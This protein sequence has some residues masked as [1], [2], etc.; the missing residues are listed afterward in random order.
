MKT[1]AFFYMALMAT[2]MTFAAC[3]QDDE[4][5]TVAPKVAAIEFNINDGGYSGAQTR[6]EENGYQTAFTANDVCGLYI[7]GNDGNI[8]AD[9]VQLTAASED[10]KI[11]WQASGELSSSINDKYFLYYPYQPNGTGKINVSATDD[12]IFFASLINDWSVKNDQSDYA[13]GYTASDLMTAKGEVNV[14]GARK[15]TVDF[16][17]TH[18]M[19]LAVIDMPTKTVYHFT[20]EDANISDYEVTYAS[21]LTADFTDCDLKPYNNTEDGTYRYIVNPNKVA[22]SI[23]G[24]V[25]GRKLTISPSAIDSGKYK[26]YNIKDDRKHN[27]QRGDFLMRDGNLI[28]KDKSATLTDEQKANVAA[29]VF[30]SPAETDYADGNRKTPARLTDDKVMAAEHPS[31]VHGL[32]VSVKDFICEDD[33]YL[34]KD[35]EESNQPFLMKWQDPYECVYRWQAQQDKY[36]EGTNYVSIGTSDGADD[37]INKILGYQNTKVLLAY[38][39]YCKTTEGKSDYSVGPVVVIEEFK[40]TCPAPTS[41]TGWFIP[42]VKELH[43]LF[44]KDV[45]NICGRESKKIE[46]RD[47]VNNSIQAITNGDLLETVAGPYYWSSSEFRNEDGAMV[48][49]VYADGNYFMIDNDS[50]DGADKVRAVLAFCPPV[51]QLIYPLQGGQE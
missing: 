1:R 18:R 4:P 45:D 11:T 29:I 3:S 6:A 36:K 15:L 47:I 34:N 2:V 33:K 10:G 43:M 5:Q 12:A 42:S 8:K 20:N 48:F 37:N 38:N 14:E 24:K 49:D 13:K 28:S 35:D 7:I 41:S 25:N 19:A 46:T 39:E 31:C 50:K 17:M 16:N 22:V 23:T 9:N 32:A 40:K 21:K 27:L 26:T 30:W 51:Y 44:Y